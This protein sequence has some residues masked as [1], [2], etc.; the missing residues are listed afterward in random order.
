[1]VNVCRDTILLSHMT[2]FKIKPSMRNDG[3]CV[4]YLHFSAQSISYQDSK[5][6]IF[7]L[8]TT[9]TYR[10][11]IHLFIFNF[12]WCIEN[13]FR[14]KIFDIVTSISWLLK[15]LRSWK[16]FQMALSLKYNVLGISNQKLYYLFHGRQRLLLSIISLEVCKKPRP[17]KFNK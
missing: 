2:Y 4:A 5:T 16:G 1:M 11:S 15:M 6:A 7:H 14:Y 10:S 12:T 3:Q 9:I 13:I 17:T 8:S